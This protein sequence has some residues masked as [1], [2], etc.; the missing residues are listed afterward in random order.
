MTPKK[1]KEHTLSSDCWCQPE[2]RLIADQEVIV[3]NNGIRVSRPA[4]EQVVAEYRDKARK[5]IG[6]RLRAAREKAGIR[7]EAAAQQSGL[8][9][10]SLYRFEQGRQA[11]SLGR[12][13]MLAKA[14]GTTV[15]KLLEGL[16]LP[17]GI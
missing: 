5:A 15:D 16:D 1:A 8:A 3:H 17:P 14:Y 13:F 2:R 10:Q 6:E 11:P 9:L 7:A 4:D 12:A